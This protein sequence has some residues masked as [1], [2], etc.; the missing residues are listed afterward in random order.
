MGQAFHGS[1]NV[2]LG[3]LNGFSLL[4][5]AVVDHDSQSRQD[6]QKHQDQQTGPDGPGASTM[7]F[8]PEKFNKIYLHAVKNLKVA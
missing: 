6:R 3:I 7:E 1:Q 2:D 8:G 5:D 4:L